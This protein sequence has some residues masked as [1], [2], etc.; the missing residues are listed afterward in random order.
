METKFTP[1]PWYPGCIVREGR[2][3]CRSIIDECYAGGIATVHI[4]NGHKA[5]PEANLCPPL[6]E[7]KANSL[8]IAAAPDLYSALYAC[9]TVM[10]IVEPRSHKFEYLAALQQALAALKKARGE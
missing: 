5:L 7:A 4:D 6:E 9:E 2:C 8:L 3:K 1:G 10:M